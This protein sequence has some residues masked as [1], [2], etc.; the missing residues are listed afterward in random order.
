MTDYSNLKPG[1]TFEW[2]GISC[3]VVHAPYETSVLCMRAGTIN[4]KFGVPL[5]EIQP[6]IDGAQVTVAVQS[7]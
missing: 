2:N 5:S 7:E 3:I 6:K 4:G 1:D